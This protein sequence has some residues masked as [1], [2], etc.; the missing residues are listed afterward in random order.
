MGGQSTALVGVAGLGGD[1]V[2]DGVL[3]QANRYKTIKMIV[4]AR[5]ELRFMVFPFL[6]SLKYLTRIFLTGGKIKAKLI[7][8]WFRYFDYQD[9]VS[10]KDERQC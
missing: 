3:L 2:D 8:G 9:L 7:N 1:S 6:T 4:N 10:K 5:M